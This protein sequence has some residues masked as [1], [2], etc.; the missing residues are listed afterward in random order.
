MNTIGH[1]VGGKLVAG[2]SG[3]GGPVFNPATGEQSATVAFA[4][5][6]ELDAAVAAA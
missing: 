3:R 6:A 1:F 2:K 5:S 4:S